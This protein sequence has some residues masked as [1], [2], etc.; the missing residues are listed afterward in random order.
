MMGLYSKSVRFSNKYKLIFIICFIVIF[1][2]YVN[3]VIYGSLF[4]LLLVV[5]LLYFH[6][7]LNWKNN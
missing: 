4:I 5:A 3:F 7:A 1:I 6:S 2:P